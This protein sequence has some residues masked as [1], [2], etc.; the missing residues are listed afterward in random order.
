MKNK[1]ASDKEDKKEKDIVESK[2][3]K[4]PFKR[5]KKVFKIKESDEIKRNMDFNLLEVVII[6][7][8]TG[9]VVSIT[10]GLIVYNNYDKLFKKDN[11][12]N[13]TEINSFEENYNKILNGY[14]KE[15]DKDKLLE[16]AIAG[17][18]NYLGD[19]Y[20]MYIGKDETDTLESQLEG[21]YTGVGIEIVSY[22]NDSGK[23]VIEVNDVFKDSPAEKAGLKA[24]DILIELDGESLENKT[25]AYVA[26]TI[27]NGTEET[28]KIKV[29]RGKEELE[30][31]LT[32][33]LVYINSVNSY[34][35]NNI[36]YIHIKTFSATSADQIKEAIDSFKDKAK[37]LVIDVRDNTGGY[38]TSAND[39]SDLF[40]EKGKNIYQIKNRKGVITSYKAKEDVYKKFDKIAILINGSSASAS[41][42]L[43]L[44]L[45]ESANA[46]IVGTKSYGK[47]S[48]QETEILSSGAMVKY[49]TAYWLSPNGNSINEIGITPDII[50]E[51]V[52][53]QLNKAIE[54]VK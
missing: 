52:D 18:Y 2:A 41:E 32:R 37:S 49:T 44:A 40:I 19:S 6:I 28:H 29:Q 26:D 5:P 34:V 21:K 35:E 51:N 9:I 4:K 24:G 11:E 47:G 13:K 14:V 43:A 23:Q 15:V 25:S 1:K 54:A 42:I 7:I 3:E 50:E 8:I 48:V 17:M 22:T 12:A 46:T 31:T 16:A 45:K 38:L 53:N 36:G 20:S 10:S 39:I 30:L 33:A 27:K